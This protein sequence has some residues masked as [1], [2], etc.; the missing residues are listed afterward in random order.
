LCDHRASEKLPKIRLCGLSLIHQLRL[1]GSQQHLQSGVLFIS[2]AT[3]GTENSLAE[4]N[5]ESTGGDKG[6]QHF[7]G[8][9]I[10]KNLQLCGRA[11]YRA[12]RKNLDSR[13]Q[14]DEPVQCASGGDPL[15]LYKILNLLFFHPVPILCALRL[16]SRKKLSTWS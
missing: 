3:W 13:T 7:G 4:I 14:L 9:K 16:E 15:L 2:F 6:F 5:L 8:S 11:H 10:G 1:L 12:T